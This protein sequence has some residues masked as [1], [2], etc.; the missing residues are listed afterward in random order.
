MIVG[1][2]RV[3]IEGVR[4]EV[5]RDHRSKLVFG[6][7]VLFFMSPVIVRNLYGSF[8]GTMAQTLALLGM[9]VSALMFILGFYQ[10]TPPGKLAGPFRYLCVPG[11]RLR[12][13]PKD[14]RMLVRAI[15]NLRG[16]STT[17]PLVLEF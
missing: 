2:E 4:V 15:A 16:A 6:G 10:K 7:G 9:I 17:A 1:D 14:E 13:A 5:E 11:A 3:P 8:N 12:L